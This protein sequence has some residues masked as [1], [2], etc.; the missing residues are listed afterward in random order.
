MGNALIGGTKEEPKDQVKK[1]IQGKRC[2]DRRGQIGQTI[3][4]WHAGLR[5]AS[6]LLVWS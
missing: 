1:K 6:W 4:G 3:M 5:G 2:V